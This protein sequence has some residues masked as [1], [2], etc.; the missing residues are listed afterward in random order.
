MDTLVEAVYEHGVFRPEEP[1]DLPEGERVSLRVSRQEA[2]T[3]AKKLRA[4]QRV[5]EGLT[6]EEVDDLERIALDRTRFFSPSD[7]E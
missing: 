4:W 7:D 2:H 1:V 3:A 5:Y 6:P